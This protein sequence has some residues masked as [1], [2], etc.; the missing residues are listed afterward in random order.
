MG[1]DYS[2]DKLLLCTRSTPRRCGDGENL[3]FHLPVHPLAV[4]GGIPVFASSDDGKFALRA[5]G[6]ESLPIY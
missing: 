4:V 5:A 3:V 2:A 6:K 1:H